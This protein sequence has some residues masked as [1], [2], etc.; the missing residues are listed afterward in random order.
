MRVKLGNRALYTHFHFTCSL[1]LESVGITDLALFASSSSYQTMLLSIY[2]MIGWTIRPYRTS[3][4]LLPG[5][6]LCWQYR[7]FSRKKSY[8]THTEHQFAF[9][10]CPRC[11]SS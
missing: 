11:N 10:I 3:T 7:R 1:D 4:K 9:C 2:N 5:M 6:K 8:S